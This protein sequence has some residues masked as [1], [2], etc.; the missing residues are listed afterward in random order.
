MS[1]IQ[2]RGHCQCCGRI[3][4]VKS[5]HMSKHGYTVQDGWFSG[6]CQGDS[7]GPMET[8]IEQTTKMVAAVRADVIKL[9]ADLVK[10]EAGKILP[11]FANSTS[12]MPGK[13]VDVLYADA[14]KWDQESAVSSMIWGTKSRIKMGIDWA[15]DME[16]LAAKTVGKPLET[17]E[18]DKDRPAPINNGEKRLLPNGKIAVVEYVHGP[19]VYWNYEG[20][21]VV[22]RSSVWTGTT[23]W[24]KYP[25]V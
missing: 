16:A 10:M 15:N 1:R 3:Q 24:R 12:C 22:R 19:R 14:P 9:E 13:K 21:V 25:L 18:K 23:S 4:A 11:K 5:G 8:S 20:A 2:V 7:Y 6:V 17:V